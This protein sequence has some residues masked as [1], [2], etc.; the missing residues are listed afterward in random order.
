MVTQARDQYFR[1]NFLGVCARKQLNSTDA[2]H[3]GGIPGFVSLL[4]RVPSRNI[5]YFINSNDP[6]PGSGTGEAITALS[7]GV[8]D[9]L[10]GLDPIDWDS[11]IIETAIKT[12]SKSVPTPA[13]PAAPP[14]A[15][16]VV[17]LYSDPA[18]GEFQLSRVSPQGSANG[19]GNSNDTAQIATVLDTLAK[20]PSVSVN[21][22]GDVY[23]APLYKVFGTYIV[24]TPY[25]GPGFIWTTVIVKPITSQPGQY[26]VFTQ[27]VGMAVIVPG[28]GIGMFGN[29]WGG[30][31]GKTYNA[32]S[33]EAVDKQS[34]V[35]FA[36]VQ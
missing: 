7:Y 33:G 28:G 4:V 25:D 32:T 11:R 6:G 29:F 14:S 24:F 3:G 5:A 12:P 9:D 8:L 22:T 26:A 19:T 21:L 35:W 20:Y 31:A 16:K 18:Y 36:K 1:S 2:R 10:L 13:S 27:G 15:D 30:V 17:G 34:E 23:V